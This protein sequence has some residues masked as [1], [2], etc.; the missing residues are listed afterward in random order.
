M[1]MREHPAGKRVRELEEAGRC[2]LCERLKSDGYCPAC[3]AMHDRA[4]EM[5]S[6][7]GAA[8]KAKL[9]DAL[10]AGSSET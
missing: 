8:R 5:W 9:W 2:V 3:I 4:N 6:V 7:M 1:T 10:T